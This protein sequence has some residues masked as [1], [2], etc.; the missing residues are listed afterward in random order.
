MQPRYRGDPIGDEVF[1][2]PI[3]DADNDPLLVQDAGGPPQELK[4]EDAPMPSLD[5]TWSVLA[6]EPGMDDIMDK[7][8]NSL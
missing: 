1:E 8:G 6:L 5:A 4:D 7:A 2:V 3:W